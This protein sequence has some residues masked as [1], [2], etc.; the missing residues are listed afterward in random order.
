M[1][2]E[3]RMRSEVN[4]LLS[5]A[6]KPEHFNKIRQ[7]YPEF[8]YEEDFENLLYYL[9]KDRKCISGTDFCELILLLKKIGLD[10]VA[11]RIPV[12]QKVPEEEY[13]ALKKMIE[14]TFDDR[15]YRNKYMGQ[16][17]NRI[18]V[19][20]KLKS[21]DFQECSMREIIEDLEK[22]HLL[23]K[24]ISDI[25]KFRQVF[26]TCGCNEVVNHI[27]SL[28]NVTGV[29]ET[30]MDT[31][32]A[33]V[34]NTPQQHTHPSG[35]RIPQGVQEQNPGT[36]EATTGGGDHSG[37]RTSEPPTTGASP[38]TGDHSS[39]RPTW[40]PQNTGA[41]P[42]SDSKGDCDLYDER[43]P[44]DRATDQRADDKQTWKLEITII[45]TFYEA[46][47][48]STKR[49]IK[50]VLSI[51]YATNIARQWVLLKLRK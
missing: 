17:R 22:L 32:D 26:M 47:S 18:I 10:E 20:Y 9:E 5:A 39:G 46:D 40:Q 2:S 11:K 44:F 37:I 15:K 38:T 28:E 4:D 19:S 34:A 29:E 6:L 50:F 48:K 45:I 7:E 41:S 24:S 1:G 27:N 43:W 14:M 25:L 31:T 21:E 35:S 36:S 13:E 49:Q 30:P 33:R 3:V 8:A 51:Q 12:A 42:N 16:F 23:S